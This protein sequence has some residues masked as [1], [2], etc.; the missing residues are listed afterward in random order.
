MAVANDR[1]SGLPKEASEGTFVR[2]GVAMADWSQ[3][4]FPDAFIFALIGVGIVFLAGL[5][6]GTPARDLVK[7]FGDGF[8]SLIPL[9]MQMALI[10][11]GG[12]VVASS[13]PAHSLIL[14]L[15]G[16][17]R[18]PKSAVVVVAFFFDAHFVDQLGIQPRNQRD[19]CESRC[20]QCSA[21]GLSRDWRGGLSGTWHRVGAGTFILA[22]TFN[23]HADVDS[24]CPAKNKRRHSAQS[25]DL[26]AAESC[27][28]RSHYHRLYDRSVS[29]DAEE[30]FKDC[31][32]FWRDRRI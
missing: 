27:R 12:Y 17:P 13:P 16:L 21:R 26:F 15:A 29:F 22:G 28:G 23:G 5:L 9:T 18:T 7:Y 31:G 3:Q 10:I 14:R 6:I 32:I 4:W 11:I 19:S 30:L 20:S 25:N 2:V 24:G 8:W 1:G